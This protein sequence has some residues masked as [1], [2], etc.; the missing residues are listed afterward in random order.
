[1]VLDQTVTAMGSRLLK[2]WIERPLLSEQH[3]NH[4]LNIVETFY[5][6]FLERDRLRESLKSVYDLERLAGRISFGNVNARDLIQL[7]QS[8]MNI[9]TIK[10]VLSSLNCQ[11]IYKLNKKL[12]YPKELITLLETSIK[13]EP[14]IS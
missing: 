4:R 5:N 8:L 2:K 13:D 10:E 6:S 9:P 1:W 11:H 12:T 14:P 7:K 3:I